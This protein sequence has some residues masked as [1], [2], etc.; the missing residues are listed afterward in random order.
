M[1]GTSYYYKRARPFLWLLIVFWAA[2]LTRGLLFYVAGIAWNILTTL[3]EW[4]KAI[5]KTLYLLGGQLC[6]AVPATGVAYLIAAR[7]IC[8]I[9]RITYSYISRLL[10]LALSPSPRPSRRTYQYT[11]THSNGEMYTCVYDEEEMKDILCD[12][13]EESLREMQ[14]MDEM[15]RRRNGNARGASGKPKRKNKKRKGN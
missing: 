2:Y 6:L 8:P 14:E 13:L 9:I 1:G 5:A 15:D 7:A 3:L 11:H 10:V 4:W 12:V